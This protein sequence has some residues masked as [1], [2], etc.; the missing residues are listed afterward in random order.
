MSRIHCSRADM[1]TFLD[2]DELLDERLIADTRLDLTELVI[3]RTELAC[4][5]ELDIPEDIRVLIVLKLAVETR[6]VGGLELRSFETLVC[7]TCLAMCSGD[8]PKSGG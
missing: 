5:R 3:E 2:I 1:E 7:E 4:R 8:F 6:R